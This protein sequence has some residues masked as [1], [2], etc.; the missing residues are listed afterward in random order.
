MEFLSKLTKKETGH[1]KEP[2]ELLT[3]RAAMKAFIHSAANMYN[4]ANNE[5]EALL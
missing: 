2:P 1:S 5:Y 4:N 3:C